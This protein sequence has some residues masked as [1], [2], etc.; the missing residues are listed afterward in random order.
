MGQMAAMVA[1]ELNQPLTAITNYTEAARALLDRGRD[2][3][4]PRISNAMDRASEQAIR[5]GQ[6]IQRLRGFVSRG[7]SE[8]RIEAIPPLIKETAELAVTGMRQKGVSIKFE[9]RPAE[10]SV[11]ADR[12]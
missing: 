7:D 5:A 3:P 4:L 11:V 10:I 12:I 9:D 8:R 2:L 1:H 6:I